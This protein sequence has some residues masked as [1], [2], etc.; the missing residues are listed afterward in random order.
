MFILLTKE[1]G[2]GLYPSQGTPLSKY[3]WK[4]VVLFLCLAWLWQVKE[5]G[6]VSL[7]FQMLKRKVGVND[8]DI[9]MGM[10]MLHYVVRSEA[11]SSGMCTVLNYF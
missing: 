9:T 5:Y 3:D 11:I 10:S 7:L 4:G 6:N 2:W 1:C 8:I